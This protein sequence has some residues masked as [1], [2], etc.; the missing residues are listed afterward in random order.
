MEENKD[1]SYLEGMTIEEAHNS[2]D[3]PY[4]IHRSKVDGVSMLITANVDFNRIRV[5]VENNK[6]SKV[7]GLG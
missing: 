3:N 7:L 6:I 2:M 4:Y 1:F 5:E